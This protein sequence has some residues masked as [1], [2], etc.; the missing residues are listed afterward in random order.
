MKL[1]EAILGEI[2]N[3]CQ[4]SLNKM[5]MMARIYKE[6][7]I[8]AQLIASFLFTSWWHLGLKEIRVENINILLLSTIFP[9]FFFNHIQDD[10][11]AGTE[12][13]TF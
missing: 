13:Y 11:L 5:E 12:F 2:F 1:P 3:D 6:A 7:Q 4:N 8:N 9:K 10:I